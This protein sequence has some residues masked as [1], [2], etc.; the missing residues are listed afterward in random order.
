MGN[1]INDEI[2]IDDVDTLSKDLKWLMSEC[3][4]ADRDN[5]YGKYVNYAD[6]L[7]Y[8]NAKEAYVVGHI[9]KKQWNQLEMRYQQ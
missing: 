1:F 6:T 2:V 5:N 4:A 9:T 8:T 3:E 7:V